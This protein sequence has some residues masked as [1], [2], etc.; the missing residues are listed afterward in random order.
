[1]LTEEEK[2]E[3]LERNRPVIS[4]QAATALSKPAVAGTPSRAT[5]VGASAPPRRVAL[6]KASVAP[7][8]KE[9]GAESVVKVSDPTFVDAVAQVE[10][11]K[12]LVSPISPFPE[13]IER[14]NL[15]ESSE[16]LV[17][18]M[19]EAS[20]DT[21]GTD[22]EV[23]FKPDGKRPTFCRDCL[24][25]YQRATAKVRDA[26]QKKRQ[27]M[28]ERGTAE[29]KKPLKKTETVAYVS[30]DQPMMLSQATHMVPKKIK[31][32]R[33]RTKVDLNDVRSM[34]SDMRGKNQRSQ[35]EE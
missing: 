23:P 33:S 1:M 21:C 10:K 29:E 18:T 15:V 6:P 3:L 8:M 26:D 20:C 2:R 35:D 9:E 27:S 28:T 12:G 31:T 13:K 19:Y 30:P 32:L 17:K 7:T 22:I 11:E 14:E 34:I 16:T 25:D 24:R 4:A 5:A